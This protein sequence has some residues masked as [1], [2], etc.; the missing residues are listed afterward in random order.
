MSRQIEELE[1]YKE[2]IRVLLLRLNNF[3]SCG[4]STVIRDVEKEVHA[5][6]NPPPAMETVEVKRWAVVAPSGYV[7]VTYSD[8][9]S[10]ESRTASGAFQGYRVVPLTG[11]YQ[12]P[13]KQK[14][15]RSVSVEV[16]VA[17][18]GRL[19]PTLMRESPV[20]LEGKTGTL[21]FTWEEPA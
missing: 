19:L 8:K 5:I 3:E 18:G 7:E 4:Y 14:V 15:E 10:A 21:T 17:P 2:A 1:R 12:R 13:V 6:L 16:V 9:E 11:T 20:D